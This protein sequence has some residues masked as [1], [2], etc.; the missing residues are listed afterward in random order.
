MPF[1]QIVVGPPGCGKSTYCHGISQFYSA[2]ERPHA[3]INLDPANDRI[4][5]TADV[6]ISELI[7]LKTVMEQHELGPNGGLIY[8]MEYLEVNIEWLFEKLDS[9]NDKYLI[10]DCP[11]Q[12]ELFTVHNSLKNIIQLLE[13]RNI[14]LCIVNLMDSHYCIDPAKYLSMLMISLKTMLRLECPHLNILSKIDLLGSY[15]K[16]GTYLTDQEFKLDYYTQVQ[17]LSYLLERLDSDPFTK[18][19]RNL[20]SAICELVEEFGLVGFLTLCINDKE[21]VLHVVR[22]IDKANGYVFGG[23]ERSNE[24]IFEIADRWEAWDRYNQEVE[25]KYIGSSDEII[26][27]LNLC[28]AAQEIFPK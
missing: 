11:G 16:L 24:S 13:K 3:V 15:G 1:A 28:E 27:D 18:K 8:C 2:I 14:R 9:L 17:D 22:A 4:P 19:Y 26:E 5:Y 23:L 6:D 7:S 20:N 10:V 21:S 25:E 12:V